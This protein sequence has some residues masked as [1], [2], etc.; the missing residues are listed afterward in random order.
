MAGVSTATVSRVI[1]NDRRIS[2]ETKEKVLRVVR[3]AGY[4]VNAVARGLKTRRTHSV[5]LVVPKLAEEF[6]MRI[7]HGI[8]DELRTHGYGVLICNAAE[9]V[10]Q[11]RDRIGLLLEK[12]VDGMI[13]IPCSGEGRHFREIQG[14]GVPVVI[15]DRL[16]RGFAADAVVVDNFDGTRRAVG[17]II[18]AGYGRVG[19]IGAD[20]S[21]STAR[22]R[23]RGYLRALRDH[24]MRLDRTIVRFGDYSMESGYRAMESITA[25]KEP[26]DHVFIINYYMSLG[27]ARFLAEK[28]I[29]AARTPAISTF[30][31]LGSARLFAPVVYTV[32]QPVVE[33]GTEAARLLLRRMEEGRRSKPETVKLKT[34]FTDRGGAKMNI[35]HN[36]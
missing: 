4:R 24:G 16:V 36:V 23:Y 31:E 19:L 3:K 9:N 7:A 13:I 35:S 20:N 29:H 2:A 8:E 14:A 33:I 32:T 5:G 30:D 11:E 18:Q 27:A 15:V 12:K 1:N 21:I 10:T 17:E 28:G 6:F 26:P 22:E 25:G 34:G